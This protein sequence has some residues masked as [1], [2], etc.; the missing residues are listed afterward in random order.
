MAADQNPVKDALTL[1]D[2]LAR[3]YQ[4][5]ATVLLEG[6]GALGACQTGVYEALTQV[7]FEPNWVAGVSIGILNATIIAGNATDR[8]IDRLC[9]FWD[10]ICRPLLLPACR[11]E[12]AVGATKRRQ[13]VAASQHGAHRPRDSQVS[14]DLT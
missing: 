4:N 3:D 10:L 1:A 12:S 9:K 11:R 13:R 8:R 5:V 6:G 2:Q 7:G 14:S